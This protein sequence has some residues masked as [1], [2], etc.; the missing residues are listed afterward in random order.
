M[1][2][3]RGLREQAYKTARDCLDDPRYTRLLLRLQLWL[4]DGSWL[5][6]AGRGDADPAAEPAA[7]FAARVLRKRSKTLLKKGK[8]RKTLSEAQYHE[9]RIA[10]KKLRYAAEF[11]ES[12][13]PKAAAKAYR[14]RVMAL[15]ETL[16]SL[17]DAVVGHRLLDEI[18]A[19]DRKR[20]RASEEFSVA[21]G[22]TMGWQAAK[23]ENDLSS[24]EA[25]WKDFEKR[26]P[27]WS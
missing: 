24:F 2:R 22:M 18:E 15:Q 11:F 7:A 17:N 8:K 10:A 27:Y 16:G 14:A 21:V 6:P 19:A 12:L 25:A 9:I 23:I 26:K 3:A 20:E 1:E 5:A 4:A 13:F